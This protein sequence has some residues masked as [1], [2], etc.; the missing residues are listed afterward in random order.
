MANITNQ[1]LRELLEQNG[2]KTI[3]EEIG[4]NFVFICQKS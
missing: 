3:K 1:E 4:N 2:F